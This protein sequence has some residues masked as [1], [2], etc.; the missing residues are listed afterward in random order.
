MFH[1]VFKANQ[2]RVKIQAALTPPLG[3]P[4][5]PALATDLTCKICFTIMLDAVMINN[6]RIRLTSDH[7]DEDPCGHQ[8]C[9]SCIKRALVTKLECPTCRR[10]AFPQ[11][12]V[13]D[14][15]VRRKIADLHVRCLHSDRGC[16]WSGELG[17]S[18][19]KLKE[20]LKTCA[21][22]GAACSACQEVVLWDDV[23]N[24]N[25]NVCPETKIDCK[26]CNLVLPRRELPSHKKICI[27]R[28]EMCTFKMCDLFECQHPIP[29]CLL[30]DHYHRMSAL[31][32]AALTS[33]QT[34]RVKYRALN[35]KLIT[36][37][38]EEKA[39]VAKVK[40]EI[41]TL[42]RK[43]E[44]E[45]SSPLASFVPSLMAVGQTEILGLYSG[46]RMWKLS[47]IKTS[48]GITIRHNCPT[49][50]LDDANKYQARFILYDHEKKSKTVISQVKWHDLATFNLQQ[51]KAWLGLEPVHLG[52][53]LYPILNKDDNNVNNVSSPVAKR[54]RTDIIN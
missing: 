5:S 7:D 13:S 27:M 46:G 15:A 25:T 17:K 34:G 42:K 43:Q 33:F 31:H 39:V 20:H 36:Q 52:I 18:F 21:H 32:T 48:T 10:T 26:D 41:E 50:S 14:M 35:V 6:E 40:S 28:P 3:S 51:S 24:H 23:K 47:I 4:V 30:G 1:I 19:T 22:R 8:F 16:K 11:F 29:Y 12:L 37:L 45:T 54:A 44:E 2:G 53:E 49:Q 9:K 38:Q